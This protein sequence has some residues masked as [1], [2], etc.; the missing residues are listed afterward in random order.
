MHLKTDGVLQEIFG[1]VFAFSA[2]QSAFGNSLILDLMIYREFGSVVFINKQSSK[3][4]CVY[5]TV[6]V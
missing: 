4:P 5:V 2:K 1:S 6:Q 3:S